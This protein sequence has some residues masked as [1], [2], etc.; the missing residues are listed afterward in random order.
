MHHLA[1]QGHIN[2]EKLYD[3]MEVICSGDNAYQT[4]F[5]NDNMITLN[6]CVLHIHSVIIE[7]KFG[8]NLFFFQ[9]Q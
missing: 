8:Q 1:V 9:D 7:H 2:T 4:T 3:F 5:S 6:T